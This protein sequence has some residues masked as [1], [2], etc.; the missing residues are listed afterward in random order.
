[1]TEAMTVE[2]AKELTQR[3]RESAGQLWE[4]IANAYT[5]RVWEVLG[6]SSWD[7]YVDAEFGDLKLRLPREERQEVVRSLHEQGL[8]TRAIASAIGYDKRT[9]S[10]DLQ[11]AETDDDPGIVTGRNGKTYKARRTLPEQFWTTTGNLVKLTEKLAK[12]ASDERFA[13]DKLREANIQ[14]L[15]EVHDALGHL[16]KVLEAA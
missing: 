3:I 13:K 5:H 4:L 9:V 1:M 12:L 16:I 10:R 8:S 2:E 7:E 6:Y 11:A 15:R 14:H